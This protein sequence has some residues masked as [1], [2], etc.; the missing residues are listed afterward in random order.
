MR[1]KK[2]PQLPGAGRTRA[3]YH[4]GSHMPTSPVKWP[5]NPN[6]LAASVAARIPYLGIRVSSIKDKASY[7][8]VILHLF[9]K[10]HLFVRLTIVIACTLQYTPHWINWI[11]N[12]T[13]FVF[14]GYW[15]TGPKTDLEIHCVFCLKA[16]KMVLEVLELYIKCS[17][18]KFFIIYHRY[19]HPPN[20][21]FG[22]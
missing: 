1:F 14:I 18:S 4:H 16:S 5:V 20:T 6:I 22:S 17:I 12:N 21:H 3:W 15:F 19:I 13:Q 7:S 10:L 9:R 8:C 11:K 2:S